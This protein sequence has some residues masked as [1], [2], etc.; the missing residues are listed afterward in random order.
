MKSQS[1]VP[2]CIRMVL[3]YDY[4]DCATGNDSNLLREKYGPNEVNSGG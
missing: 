4:L 2:L 3:F 1:F